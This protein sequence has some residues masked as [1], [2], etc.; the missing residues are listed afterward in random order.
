MPLP[1]LEIGTFPMT[2]GSAHLPPENLR[3]TAARFDA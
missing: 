3:A 1:N 2:Q